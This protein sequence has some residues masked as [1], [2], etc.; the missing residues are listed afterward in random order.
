MKGSILVIED[1]P[2]I[3][4]MLNIAF[5]DTGLKA[6]EAETGQDGIKA[7][8]HHQPDLILLDI[9]LPDI[10]GLEV[11]QNVR[12]WSKV[13]IIVLSANGQENLKVECLESGADDYVTK[14]FGVAELLARIRVVLRREIAAKSPTDSPVFVSGSL[15]V[16]LAAREVFLA[17]E[18][19]RLTPL[20]YKLLTTLIKHAGKIV[21]HRQL[22]SEVWGPDYTEESQY[23][24]L[25][26]GYLRKKLDDGASFI[27][28]EPGVGY[29]LLLTDSTAN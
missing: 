14:P 19:I 29:R 13:P 12:T 27:V 4:R 20:E 6:I 25:Y 16:D 22:L 18:R 7:V 24:R 9:G 5:Q 3:R 17:G 2:A 28:N 21:T 23:L 8:V 10:S 11:V 1:D 26:I 15:K